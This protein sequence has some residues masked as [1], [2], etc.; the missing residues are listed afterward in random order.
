MERMIRL[1]PLS[2]RK[3]RICT[4][5]LGAALAMGVALPALAA[6]AELTANPLG[7]SA[8]PAAGAQVGTL[9]APKDLGRVASAQEQTVTVHLKLHN[10]AGF[11]QAVAALYDPTSSTFHRWF[12]DKDFAKYA[13]TATELQTVQAELERHGMKTVS[14]DPQNFSIR[15]RGNTTATESAFHTEL[16]TLS[17]GNSVVQAA[18]GEPKL[19][20][21]AGDLVGGVVG[22]ERHQAQPQLVI[23]K[24]PQTGKPMADFPITQFP[25]ATVFDKFVVQTALGPATQTNIKERFG[26]VSESFFGPL[27]AF[28]FTQQVSYT[29]SQLQGFYGMTPLISQGYDGRG[30]TIA[31]VD[32]FGYANAEADANAAA[33]FFGLPP[34]TSKNF[35]VVYPDGPPGNPND[36][37]LFG[38]TGEIALDIQAAHA[39]APGA[40]IV[41]VAAAG[42]DDE[43]LISALQYILKHKVATIVSCSWEV[44]PEFLAGPAEAGAFNPVLQRM[45]AAGISVQF[46]SGD[47]GDFGL[48]TPVGAVSVP[49]DSPYATAVGG[50]SVMNDPVSGG[51]LVT[52]WGT[53]ISLLGTEF[54]VLS[55]PDYAGTQGSGGGESIYNSK[56]SWQS[57]L[58]GIG[59]QV[60]DV[61]ALADPFTGFSVV[62]TTQGTQYAVLGVGGTSLASPVFSAIWAVAQQYNNA[63]LGQAAPTI[64]KLKAGQIT[65]VIDTSDMTQYSLSGTIDNSGT[66]T[67][68]SGAGFFPGADIAQSNFLVALSPLEGFALTYAI[69]FGTDGSL[70]VGPGWDNVTGYGTPNGLPFI[71]AVGAKSK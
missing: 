61:S 66:T 49:S 34:L 39:I 32:A 18:I 19:A 31:L 21:A 57:K 55:A 14:V 68:Y 3:G 11:D 12:T 48:G 42:Q 60:P 44:D 64:A 24:N 62:A 23:A 17:Y 13:P 16:H 8:Q 53:N 52:G 5:A 20:G 27:F 7:A 25:L 41:E 46:S 2:H 15:V 47:S 33:N 36:A 4:F 1:R 70:T 26:S 50:T 35:S 45:A 22:V 59:R 40:N 58:P 65:D 69:S 71:Q 43:D 38:W 29:P 37:D 54:Q 6:A 10:Q 30:Q 56:P 67:A 9:T 51:N 63:T 28:E